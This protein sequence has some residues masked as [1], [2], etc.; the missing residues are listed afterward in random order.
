MSVSATTSYA[1]DVSKV[2]RLSA[3]LKPM[4]NTNVFMAPIAVPKEPQFMRPVNLENHASQKIY[5]TVQVNGR[6][7]ATLYNNGSM[8]SSNAD[9]GRVSNLPSVR[10]DVD[11]SGPEMAQLRA[12][13]IAK[14]LGGKIVKA[15]TAITQ[16]QYYALP[17][18]R[19]EVD[20][21]ALAQ[22]RAEQ[23][24]AEAEWQKSRTEGSRTLLTAQLLGAGE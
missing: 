18:I 17:P 1:V 10:G 14:A 3:V 24:A 11:G 22:Y 20:Q 7:V 13:E 12:E 19:F 5:A 4:E 15:N 23:S 21:E 6:T 9:Y 2:K 16:T 8:M